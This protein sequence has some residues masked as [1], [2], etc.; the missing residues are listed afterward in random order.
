MLGMNRYQNFQYDLNQTSLIE[1]GLE[2]GY[3]KPVFEIVQFVLK[4]L[5]DATY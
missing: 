5:C 1:Y 4:V 2:E 3:T